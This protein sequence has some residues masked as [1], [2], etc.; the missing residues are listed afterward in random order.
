MH[1]DVSADCI[2]YGITIPGAYSSPYYRADYVTNIMAIRCTD[3]R[4]HSRTNARTHT[5]PCSAAE[6]GYSQHEC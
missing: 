1:R 6:T 2:T 4:A 3:T 5:R